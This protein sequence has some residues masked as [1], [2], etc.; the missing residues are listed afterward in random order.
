M[1]PMR[2]RLM[3]EKI[4]KASEEIKSGVYKEAAVLSAEFALSEE[5]V[6]FDRKETLSYKAVSVG[7][8]WS[9][10]VW[11][12]AWFHITGEVP[13]EYRKEDLCLGIDV[14][15]EGCLF[16]SDGT[17][18]R[19]IT[20]VSS[21]FD[22]SLGFPG[23]RYVPFDG[24]FDADRIDLWLEAGNNDL[25]GRFCGGKVRQLGIYYCNRALRDL[26]YDYSFL[27][28]LAESM[29]EREPLKMGILYALEKVAVNISATS[30]QEKICEMREVLSEYLDRKGPEKPSL[31]FYAVGHSHLDLAW[32]WPIRE[33]KRKAG[34]TF[35]T[36]LANI[37]D[38]PD[39]I[40]GASQP[41]QFE[42]VKEQYP[43][44]F[45]KI[46]E[47]VSLGRIEVQ[48]GMWVE[49]DTN[50]TGGESLIR[51]FYYGKKFWKDEFGKEADTLW[52]P[53]VFGFT[54]ALPQI[55]KGC[56]CEN[57]L[58]IKISWNMVN[59]FPYHSFRWR[60]IDGSEVLVHMPPEGTYNS[61]ASPHAVRGAAGEYSERGIADCAM[62]LYGIGDGGGGPSRA[63]LEYLKREKDVCGLP[64]VKS[65]PSSEFFE[66]LEK[67]RNALPVYRGEMYLERHQGTY[68]SQS[69]NKR[70]NRLAENSLA[71]TEF[72]YALCG[73]AD[74]YKKLNGYWK[75]ILLYQFHD[76]LPGSSIR[77]VYEESKPRYEKILA[78]LDAETE[79]TLRK[80]GGALCALNSTSYFRREYVFRDGEYYLAEVKPYSVAKLR[81]RSEKGSCTAERN[82]L[83]NRF[84]IAE[85]DETGALVRLYDKEA[86][87][88]T[89]RQ[90]NVLRVY[91]DSFDAWDTYVGYVG[92]ESER[93]LLNG[94]EI[95]NDGVKA[96]I[97]SEY[98]FGKSKL[99]QTAY[100]MEDS[101]E[102]RFETVVDWQ[103]TKKMLRVDF[104]PEIFAEEVTCDIQFGN[105]RR[106]MK[107]N[108]SHE[109]AQYEICAH[110]WV[111]MSE[112]NY[113]VAVLNDCKYGYRAKNGI[114]SLNL[115]RS[116]MYPC[117]GQDKGLQKFTYSVLPHT[118]DVYDGG[119]AQAAYALNRPL[120]VCESE[121]TDSFA[122]TDNVHAVIDGVKPAYDG[123][124]VIVRVYNDTPE[125]QTA[126]LE[127]GFVNVYQTDMLENDCAE[128]GRKIE[129]RPFEIK[130]LRLI[131]FKDGFAD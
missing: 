102:V 121:E 50:I 19:G 18:V 119:V 131:P 125:R 82:R 96:G 8:T 123:N 99:T 22:R 12:C 55:M 3:L 38:Y 108:D 88:E 26:F 37:K 98:S 56:G 72:V 65:A 63:H 80:E 39:Y 14:E 73:K 130:T 43:A 51:Q 71:R 83:E 49:P 129:F 87:R 58:T 93:P 86:G 116:Q 40:Y 53:D 1:N 10:R 17:P 94:S 78:D 48:G 122:C 126:T 45:G 46:R 24:T 76:I 62:M 60:G 69:E 104:V 47:Q 54:G 34:R 42:W 81:K 2:M 11:D 15:G 120:F 106:S 118:G 36:A 79:K 9:E 89:V 27:K 101:K 74:P 23:K 112:R 115:L 107:E 95:F 117:V 113:G 33:T 28:D 59:R 25:F 124:G 64:R 6:P 111:D 68:T 16:S 84:L 52:L 61:S 35:S 90:G 85:F 110:K 44:L 30:P 109:W 7:D 32:L 77:R 114:I 31:T 92:S 13:T 4:D 66:R 57:L 67:Q 127:G 97:R 105:I 20:N 128:V 100:I 70:Y 41:Q 21:E 5:P 91:E 29:D 75:E 103:E